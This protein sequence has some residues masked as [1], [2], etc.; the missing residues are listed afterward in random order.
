[1]KHHVLVH[2]QEL[3]AVENRL[4]VNRQI[5]SVCDGRHHRE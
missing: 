4:E 1:M 3:D 5:I 2:P